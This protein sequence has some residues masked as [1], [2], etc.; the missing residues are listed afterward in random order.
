V[1]RLRPIADCGFRIAD[2][3]ED[4]MDA[5]ELKKRTKAF[6]LRCMRLA[7]SLPPTPSGRVIAH[8]LLRSST[9]V[10]ANYRAACRARSVAEFTSKMGVV[11]EEVDETALWMELI[12][13]SQ[14]ATHRFVMPLC[15]EADELTRIVVASIRTAR[16]APIRNPKSAIRNR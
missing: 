7:D 12:M 3:K 1:I 10:A 6:A 16:K 2:L 9:S 13:E 4:R 8:Q 14:M 15:Q 11:E 5:T